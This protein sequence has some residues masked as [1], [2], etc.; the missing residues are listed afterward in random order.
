M[1][2]SDLNIYSPSAYRTYYKQLERLS[3]NGTLI[4]L[5]PTNA[6]GVI[7]TLADIS[8]EIWKAYDPSGNRV[9]TPNDA[10]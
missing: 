6:D 7:F 8:R 9:D 10:L 2:F 3:R 4:C 5:P 1:L